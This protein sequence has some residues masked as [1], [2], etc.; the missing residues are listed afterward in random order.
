MLVN[1]TIDEMK[2]ITRGLFA[3]NQPGSQAIINRLVEI[4]ERERKEKE[5]HRR[6][7]V[8]RAREF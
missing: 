3:S 1:L 2:T 8:P 4:M 7:D 5:T 6:A